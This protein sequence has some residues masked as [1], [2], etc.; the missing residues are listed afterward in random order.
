MVKS[1]PSAGGLYC[2]STRDCPTYARFAV[3]WI[4]KHVLEKKFVR[5]IS[6]KK[7]FVFAQGE[8]KCFVFLM[9]RKK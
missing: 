3:E 8:K 9:E 1:N 7:L 2:E 4:F 6:G 5:D